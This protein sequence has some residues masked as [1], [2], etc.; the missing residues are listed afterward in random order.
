MVLVFVVVF[1]V[2]VVVVEEMRCDVMMLSAWHNINFAVSQVW[3]S[4]LSWHLKERQVI[5]T[6]SL[7]LA[8][9]PN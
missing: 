2:V 7:S 8:H 4:M 1:V 5:A 9:S 3:A 6:E